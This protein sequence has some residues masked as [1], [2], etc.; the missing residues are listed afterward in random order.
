MSFAVELSSR[1]FS[2]IR[3]QF[4]HGPS[5]LLFTINR[6]AMHTIVA[7]GL[8]LLSP[9]FVYVV[10]I[11]ASLIFR[12][13]FVL[14]CCSARKG[15]EIATEAARALTKSGWA[16]AQ[17]MAAATWAEC[18]SVLKHAG[19][20]R[21]DEKTSRCSPDTSNLGGRQSHFKTLK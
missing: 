8:G 16:T 4:S 13:G 5:V 11:L 10:A 2:K 18:S 14:R 9:A 12:Y 21:Y 19:Y 7:G 1:E 20:T 17:K 3:F 15:N 6:G